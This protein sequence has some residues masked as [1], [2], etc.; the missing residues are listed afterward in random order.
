MVAA[1]LYWSFSSDVARRMAWTLLCWPLAH[2]FVAPWANAQRSRLLLLPTAA[3]AEPPQFT[4]QMG[5][6]LIAA[7]LADREEQLHFA[8]SLRE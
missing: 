1:G 3:G 4:D 5:G 2:Y 8:A 6:M 7:R